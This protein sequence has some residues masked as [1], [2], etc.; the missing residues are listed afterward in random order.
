MQL[1]ALENNP[2]AIQHFKEAWFS[3]KKMTVAEISEAL[4]YDVEVVRG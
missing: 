3:A 4:G 1:A 2:E